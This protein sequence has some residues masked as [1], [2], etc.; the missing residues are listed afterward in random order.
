MILGAF[1]ALWHIPA[2]VQAG[3]S[4]EWIGWWCLWTLSARVIMVWLYNWAGAS[5]L[6]V[7]LYHA[8][9]NLCWQLYP[10]SGSYFDPQISGL[11]TLVLASAIVLSQRRRS[12]SE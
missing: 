2:L 4:L 5:V 1:W 12:R 11:I 7:G 3:R 10:V 6:A 9:S 8:T